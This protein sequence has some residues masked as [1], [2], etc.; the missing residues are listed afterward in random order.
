MSHLQ[1]ERI[2]A[3]AR[4]LRLGALAD[5]YDPIA[6]TAAKKK[7]ASYADFLEEVLRAEREV[8]RVRAREM[9]TRTAGFPAMKSLEA[10]DF[11]FA[12]ST[13][14]ARRVSRSWNSPRSVFRPRGK[15][16]EPHATPAP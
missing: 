14:P 1:H 2:A 13:R 4:E 10:Y 16:D 9:M 8:R 7:D 15:R 11:A 3:L 5:L 6:Q 12:T